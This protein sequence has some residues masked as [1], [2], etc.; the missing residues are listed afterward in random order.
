MTGNSKIVRIFKQLQE[1]KGEGVLEIDLFIDWEPEYPNHYRQPTHN[2]KGLPEDVKFI[3]FD[4]RVGTFI[5]EK[6]LTGFKG[7]FY[8][9]IPNGDVDDISKVIH[10]AGQLGNF[11]PTEDYQ[12]D[13]KMLNAL[14]ITFQL[15]ICA[16][17]DAL[18]DAG[19]PLVRSNIRTSTGK[20]LPGEWALPEELQDDTGIIFV[21]AF[22]GYDNFAEEL[23]Y[24]PAE[25][26]AEEPNNFNRA[27]LLRVLSMGHSQFA[28]LIKAKGPNTSTNAACASTP[29]AMDAYRPAH[30]H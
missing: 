3:K 13:S 30:L 27:F 1:A 12:F 2:S 25:N 5:S 16:G 24:D 18:K 11:N 29:Q 9:L 26:S 28:Q 23:L 14:D 15:A 7:N 21:S 20:I 10:L 17:Y 4:V 22:P 19:I 6:S 8:M